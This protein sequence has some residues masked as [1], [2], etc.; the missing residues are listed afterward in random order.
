MYDCYIEYGLL[1]EYG[2]N[3]TRS[4]LCEG[5]HYWSAQEN[6]C[7]KIEENLQIGKKSIYVVVYLVRK[8][9]MNDLCEIDY[10]CHREIGLVC[11]KPPGASRKIC[12]NLFLLY[13]LNVNRF[14]IDIGVRSE[15]LLG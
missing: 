7:R 8:G 13:S 6:K 2:W 3:E 5:S 4:C 15:Y 11:D 12:V 10:Q 1:C 9:E 14:L